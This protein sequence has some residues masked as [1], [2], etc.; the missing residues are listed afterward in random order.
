MLDNFP[1]RAR[2]V[3]R[4][5]RT[6]S[7]TGVCSEQNFPIKVVVMN[8]LPCAVQTDGFNCPIIAVDTLASNIFGDTLWT[9]E[10]ARPHRIKAFCVIME[11]ISLSQEGCSP[12]TAGLFD[13][14]SDCNVKNLSTLPNAPSSTFIIPDG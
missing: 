1:K 13:L 10:T 8:D 6:P 7:S 14:E 9:Q 2:S 11:S 5:S 12:A 3:S 4:S